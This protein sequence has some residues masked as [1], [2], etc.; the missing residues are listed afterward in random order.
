MPL[1]IYR[2][3]VPLERLETMDRPTLTMVDTFHGHAR[4]AC[5]VTIPDGR[6]H[7]GTWHGVIRARLVDEAS[8]DW[9]FE[10]G[11]S[12]GVSE[13]RIGKFPVEWVRRMD[14]DDFDGIVPKRHLR[15]V[16]DPRN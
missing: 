11:Y 8:G 9:W 5:V 6:D 15:A 7:A 12:T 1:G 4:E 13:H 10:L 2:L 14:L 16:E 3:P